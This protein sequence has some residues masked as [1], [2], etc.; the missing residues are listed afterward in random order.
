MAKTTWV[1]QLL[2]AG[3]LVLAAA[4][5]GDN[6]DVLAGDPGGSGGSAGEP[7]DPGGGPGSG[8]TT[9]PLPQPNRVRLPIVLV[10]GN[11][12]LH[13]LLPLDYFNGVT[14]RL[15][16]D[17]RQAFTADITPQ[18]SIPERAAQLAAAVTAVL[19]STGARRVHLIAHGTG[20][21]DAR[22]LIS[23][24]AFGDRVATL[25][26]IS[27]PHRGTTIADVAL[28]LIPGP[29][30]QLLGLLTNVLAATGPDAET[31]IYQMS[32]KYVTEEFNPA[33]PDDARVS[34]YSVAG[35]T[36][37]LTLDLTRQDLCSPVLLVG[38]LFLNNQGQNDGLVSV[39]S[40]TRGEL[41]GTIPADNYDEV[42]QLLGVSL[43]FNHRAFYSRLG[44]FISSLAAPPP[45]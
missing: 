2:V 7:G 43:A 31:A 13:D 8:E 11:V 21:L 27:T 10:R 17:G 15:T 39:A 14:A 19:A 5:C 41:L 23:N 40:A 29:T 36:N 26:T 20:G 44:N 25:T 38:L 22:Y 4:G 34:Y 32:K 30:N 33:N 6:L 28:G 35:V 9:V 45:L 16:S 3:L 12:S 18:Q 24:M 42:G 37:A 1:K